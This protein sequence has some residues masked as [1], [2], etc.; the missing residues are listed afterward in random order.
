MGKRADKDFREKI[1]H[2]HE[3][4]QGKVRSK[5]SKLVL[6]KDIPNIDNPEA[7]RSPNQKISTKAIGKERQKRAEHKRRNFTENLY[8]RNTE[9]TSEKKLPSKEDSKTVEEVK[10]KLTKTGKKQVSKKPKT[11]I[12]K[13]SVSYLGGFFKRT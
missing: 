13:R 2:D 8:T 4:F 9:A 6:G 7:E 10:E 3:R 11:A 1:L 5:D 12:K